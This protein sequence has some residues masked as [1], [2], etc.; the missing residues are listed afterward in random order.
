MRGILKISSVFAI[1]AGLI[2][3]LGG[4]WGITFTYQ[5]VAKEN[6]VTPE[7]AKIPNAKV[8]DPL[9]IKAQ[10]DIIR[11]HALKMTGGKTY[12]EMPR[13]IPSVDENG[14][15]ILDESGNP[16]METNK[17]RDI[18]VTVTSLTTALNLAILSYAFSA[19]TILM[20]VISIWTGV[21]FYFLSKKSS[22][23]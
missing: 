13:Q 18:W 23:K 21:V 15:A 10:A 6:I 8:R 2:L 20:G 22:S 16:V 19:F 12:S 7:D 11:T 14:N 4:V 5:N 3:V 9:T 17:A 1:L